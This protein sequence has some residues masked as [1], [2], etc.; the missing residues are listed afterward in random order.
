M[1]IDLHPPAASDAYDEAREAALA[2]LFASGQALWDAAAQLAFAGPW[3]AEADA[4]PAGSKLHVTTAALRALGHRDIDTLLDAYDA[5]YE[6]W[7]ALNAGRR[8]AP[9]HQP[10]N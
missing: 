9:Q 5:L 10:Q 4:A 8:A 6:A 2:H 1:T 7:L 3:R